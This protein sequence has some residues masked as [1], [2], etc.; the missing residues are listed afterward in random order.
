MVDT[1]RDRTEGE[2]PT[3]GVDTV[4]EIDER[5]RPSR[6][7]VSA[8]ATATDTRVLDLPPLYDAIDPTHLDEL[9]ADH[10]DTEDE[11]SVSFQFS[12]CRVTVTG[13]T[14]RVRPEAERPDE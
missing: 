11:R 13:D 4:V 9:I 6:A 14:V 12:G 5:A 2:A 7:V 1:D 8:V 10:A 3:D